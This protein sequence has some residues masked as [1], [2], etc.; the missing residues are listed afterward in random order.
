M[1][2][3]AL[4]TAAKSATKR[5]EALL[6]KAQAIAG[7]LFFVF[8]VM[9][10]GNAL[11]GVFGAETYNH[12]QNALR[13]V[14]QQP[15]IEFLLVI[16]PLAT[17]ATA[18]LWLHLLRKNRPTTRALRYRLQTWAG[19]FLLSFVFVH[20]LATRG[21]GWWFD[22][23]TGFE[24]VAFSLWWMP[25]YFYP[26]YLLLFSTGLYH[27]W[28]GLQT[29]LARARLLAPGAWLQS[30]KY[31]LIIGALSCS[32]ALLS[33]GGVLGDTPDPRDSDYARTYAELFSIALSTTPEQ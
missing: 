6:S 26:Y 31:L 33:F 32:A 4:D 27:G 16:I 17:H 7:M 14:Y 8:L 18:G 9:H 19:F 21:V 12:Y 30:T 10:L 11:L 1:T 20:M 2:T 15:I 13:R 24:S 29:L 25:A 3:L 22:V 28:M 5:T 23:A